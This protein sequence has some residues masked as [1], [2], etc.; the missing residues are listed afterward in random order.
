[1]PLGGE[2]SAGADLAELTKTQG[3]SECDDCVREISVS[4]SDAIKA[5]PAIRHNALQI[6]R[7]SHYSRSNNAETISMRIPGAPRFPNPQ[8]GSHG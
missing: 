7:H 8:R 6:F 5:L 2:A 4:V 1:M 3:Q